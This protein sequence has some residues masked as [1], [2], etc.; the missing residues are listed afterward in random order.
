MHIVA[1]TVWYV[2]LLKCVVS[3]QS[4]SNTRMRRQGPSSESGRLNF[5]DLHR[6]WHDARIGK[7]IL[8]WTLT[9]RRVSVQ[10]AGRSSPLIKHH[11]QRVAASVGNIKEIKYYI[12]TGQILNREGPIANIGT[13]SQ[14]FK[15]DVIVSL[16]LCY[17]FRDV[18]LL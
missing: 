6:R 9:L 3:T 13:V 15:V 4:H 12:T 11:L 2:V 16:T 14:W 17:I 7:H 10:W 18:P 1:F 5:N 8:G